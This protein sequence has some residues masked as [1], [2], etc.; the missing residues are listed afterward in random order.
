MKKH[1]LGVFALVL[2]IG[3]SSFGTMKKV[4]FR[5]LI[6]NPAIGSTNEILQTNYIDNGLSEP[7]IECEGSATVCWIRVDDFN[8]NGSI[9]PNE[10]SS[11]V[12]V[13]DTD[14]PKNNRI[15]DDQTPNGTSYTERP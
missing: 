7:S 14:S 10:F 11:Q 6:F 4:S 8:L 3:F 1:L 15:A 13:L 2:A 5:Y 12:V 9:D